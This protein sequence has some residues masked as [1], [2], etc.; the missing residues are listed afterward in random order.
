MTIT[1]IFLAIIMATV[2]TWLLR[3]TFNT[4]PWVSN[5]ADDAVSGASL[6]S[7]TKAIGLTTF[8]AVAT[9]LFALFISAYTIRMRLA[10]DWIPL[11]DPR[12]LWANTGLLVLSSIAYHWTRNAAVA[13][14]TERLKP[15]LIL[16]GSLAVLFLI[17]QLAAWNEL[18]HAGATVTNN[19]AN[20][21][22]YLLT[23][24]H[25]VHLLGGIWVWARSLVRVFGGA[26]AESVRLSIELCAVYWHYL[27][28][29]WIV[30][31]GLLLST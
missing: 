3:Q 8:L 18:T 27:L 15:G 30:L 4:Q 6:D 10:P 9:S 11:S 5:A 29:V 13:G 17:G 31:F 16:A 12:I 25:G 23:G 28:L 26:N 21:F 2:I 7:S 1:L 24:L 14:R 22:F 20:A 19:P